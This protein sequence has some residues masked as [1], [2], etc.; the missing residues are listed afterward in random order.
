MSFIP[1]GVDQL[2]FVG[3]VESLDA[4]LDVVRRRLHADVNHGREGWT[5]HRTDATAKMKEMYTPETVALVQEL[6]RDDFLAF[7]YERE[8]DWITGLRRSS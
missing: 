3:R 6:Y 1:C 4:D 7:D 8:P 2:H 5:P